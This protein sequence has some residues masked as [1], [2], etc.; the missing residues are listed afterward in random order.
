MQ[1]HWQNYWIPVSTVS[2]DD[3]KEKWKGRKGNKT[4]NN[5]KAAVTGID[6]WKIVDER[7]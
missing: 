4:V 7:R 2:L 6:N 1:D 5:K 3:D